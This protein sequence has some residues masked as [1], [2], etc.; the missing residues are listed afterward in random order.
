MNDS[1]KVAYRISRRVLTMELE[2]IQA[3][4]LELTKRQEQLLEMID[5]IDSKKHTFKKFKY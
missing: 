4:I 3:Q 2:V 5:V 1:D